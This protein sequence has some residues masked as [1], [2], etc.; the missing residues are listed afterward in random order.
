LARDVHR[1][2][3]A[4]EENRAQRPQR[5]RGGQNRHVG[6][7]DPDDVFAAI[8]KLS[9]IEMYPFAPKRQA[10]AM[11]LAVL[12]LQRMSVNTQEALRELGELAGAADVWV[13]CENQ[14]ERERFAQLLAK[15]KSATPSLRDVHLAIGHIS[16][17]FHW[18]ALRL[19][20][21][22]HHE[23]FHRYAKH[24]RMRRVRAGRPIES[25][26]DLQ[27]GEYVVHVAHGIAHFEG[28]RNLEQHGRTEEYLT[29]RFADNAVLHVPSSQINLVHK[30]VGTRALRPK[31]SKL[32]GG[33][34]AKQKQ[35]VGEA[36]RDLAADMLRIQAMRQA[37]PG[38][39]YPKVSQWQEQFRDEFLYNETEDQLV[40][41]KQIDHDLAEE[42]PMDRLLCGEVGYG[43]TE[44]AMRA[45]FKVAEAGKQVAVLV[46]TTV[47]AE[48]HYRTFTERFA[49]YPFS[50]EMLSRFRR[51][52][53]VRRIIK[54]VQLG[55]VDILIGTHR[56]LSQDVIFA[57][58]GL[59]IID[60]EQRFGVDH[61]EH[62]KQM[63]ATVDVL[64][65]TATPIPRT[66]HM[67]LL[68]LRDISSLATAPLDR[69]AIRTEV[70]QYD[71]GLIKRAI[72][73]ELNRRGQV[74]FVHNR[75]VDIESLADKVRAIV[76]DARVEVGHGQMR[77][78]K[79][80]KVMLRFVRQE[81]D[82][83]VCTTIIESGLDIPTVNTMIVHEADRFG[84][85][86]L[87]QLRGRVGRF[88]HRAFCYFLLPETRPVTPPAAKRLKA[89][90]EFSDLGAG[91]Q[92]AMRDLELRGAGNILGKAQSGHIAAVGYELYCRILESTV[93]ELR[94]EAPRR[95]QAVHVELG[96]NAYIPRSYVVAERQ[97]ME[98]YRRLVSCESVADIRRLADDL[99]DAYGAVP[100]EVATLLDSAEIRVRASLVGIESII[101]SGEDIVFSVN[102]FA[103][104]S[105]V[106]EDAPGSVRLPDDHTVHWR[107]PPAYM[108]KPT[109]IRVM[110]KRLRDAPARV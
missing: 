71:E 2:V 80:E 3:N 48:Q 6:L 82:V 106:F 7:F 22:G 31:L 9:L 88:K 63:R 25:L 45:A 5:E 81:I 44:L 77:D 104:A 28:L 21:I 46:P 83:L 72:Q 15:S 64:T 86:Q 58:L 54:D 100:R 10:G 37:M 98:I 42:R 41:M 92:I 110:L 36:V 11:N 14:A 32:G 17:G 60:E 57:D 50:I 94:G 19:A 12:S 109:L 55:R 70:C 65:L 66:L 73:R 90:E 79:L 91:F 16:S 61:K 20:V 30:Y 1:R 99:A 108:E 107:P 96:V 67:A 62:L 87:H 75:V 4:V 27:V 97:R 53:D 105:G 35:R 47:L 74:F 78:E 56:L 38:V 23:I 18:P 89:V 103:A 52:A 39:S 49:D 13:Y 69:R 51:P 8:Q 68:G 76:P 85:A 93:G 102:D 33:S 43:K 26:L 84:L 59:A 95:R 29:L 101:L 34:W 40:A 24:R